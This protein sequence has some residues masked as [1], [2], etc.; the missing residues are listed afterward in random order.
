[1]REVDCGRVLVHTV[2]ELQLLIVSLVSNESSAKNA[3]SLRGSTDRQLAYVIMTSGT[4][5]LPKIVRVPHRCIV[6]N[7]KHLRWDKSV[8][9]PVRCH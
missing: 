2:D 9:I 1:M 6:P 3:P 5:G 8:F 4:T 7:I